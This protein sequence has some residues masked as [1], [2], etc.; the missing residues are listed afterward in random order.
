M[1]QSDRSAFQNRFYAM[2]NAILRFFPTLD[3]RLLTVDGGKNRFPRI[4]AD[5]R[6][7][8]LALSPL[9]GEVRPSNK[10]LEHP[11]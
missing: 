3:S 7:P 10:T 1:N 11:Q 2:V 9:K 8:L 4:D 5:F 6:A